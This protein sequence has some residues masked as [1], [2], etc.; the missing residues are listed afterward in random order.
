MRLWSVYEVLLGLKLKVGFTVFVFRWQ[1][2][3]FICWNFSSVLLFR[4]VSFGWRLEGF[5]LLKGRLRRGWG[6]SVNFTHSEHGIHTGSVALQSMPASPVVVEL[7][8]TEFTLR[9]PANHA[10]IA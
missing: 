9:S 5:H 7:P 2:E 8:P 3:H 10:A 1:R 6:R 4:L